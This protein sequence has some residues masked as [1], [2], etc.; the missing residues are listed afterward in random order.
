MRTV[1]KTKYMGTEV[2]A[3][4]FIHETIMSKLSSEECLLTIQLRRF[5]LPSC[6]LE[7]ND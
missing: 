5:D 2:P 1:A 6:C 4:Y 3:Q 7:G